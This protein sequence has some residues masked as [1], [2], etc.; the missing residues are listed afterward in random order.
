MKKTGI[1]IA[2]GII[3]ILAALLVKFGNPANMGVCVAC[4][5]RDITGALG[6]HRAETV[7]YIRPEIIGFIL[8]AF[9]IAFTSKEFRARGGSSPLLRFVLGFFVM[10]GALVFL[11]CPLRMILRLANGD[12]NALVGLFGYIFGIVIGIQFIKKG[13]SLGRNY[14]QTAVNGYIMPVFASVLLLL[15]ITQPAFIF[16]SQKGPGATHAPLLFSLAAGLIIGAVVQK[17]RLC[18]VGGFRD[19]ILIKD[20][21]LLSGLVGI[22]V[23]ALLG[24]LIL[25]P[26]AFKIGFVDQPIAHNDFVWNFLGMTLAG[27]GSVLL[28]GCPLRQTI[29]SAEGDTDA[30]V[31][32]FGLMAGAAFAHNF[33]TAASPKGVPVN[34][35]VA[36]IIGLV[37]VL[38]IAGLTVWQNTQSTMKAKEGVALGQ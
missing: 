21:H 13:F 29:L 38:A 30:A 1:I 6:L 23:F 34:G 28:G 10:I 8:G 37:V 9:I 2:G 3:G 36:V 15:A 14:K 32:V 22:F 17:T 5:Y 33:G 7:Q 25:N 31:T 26:S 24:N 19:A 16:F 20:F 12:L 18:T 35:Q 11:G 4:F 27:L